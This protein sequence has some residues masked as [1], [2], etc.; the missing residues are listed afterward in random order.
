M[1]SISPI[2]RGEA[3]RPIVST[4]PVEN[5]AGDPAAAEVR[6]GDDRVEVSDMARMV[7]KMNA[8][9]P[10]RTDLV[11]RVK[12]EIA[13]GTYETPERVDLAIDVML[14]ELSRGL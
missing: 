9:P 8:M 10:V 14:D 3:G 11:E 2:S 13:N 7:A 4:E 1:S 12:S 5:R 6:R